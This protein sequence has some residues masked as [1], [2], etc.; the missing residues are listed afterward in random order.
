MDFTIDTVLWFFFSIIVGVL[1]LS[2]IFD[3]D[4]TGF[5]H[6]VREVISPDGKTERGLEDSDLKTVVQEAVE[7][8]KS[9]GFGEVEKTKAMMFSGMDND[10]AAELSQDTVQEK[11]V[12]WGLCQT[13][14]VHTASNEECGGKNEVQV[15]TISGRKLIQLRCDPVA[16]VLVIK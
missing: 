5:Y 9:C 7:L 15:T 16:K 1:I 12:K 8:W 3:I 4:Y 6:S 2:F 10:V 11:V 14:G 13:L